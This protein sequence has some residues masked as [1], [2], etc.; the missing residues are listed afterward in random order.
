[1]LAWL[2][3]AKNY[4][5]V[6]TYGEYSRVVHNEILP[7]FRK[8]VC[9]EDIKS[10]DIKQYYAHALKTRSVKSVRRFHANIHRA[11][12]CAVEDEDIRLE[13]NP[14]RR[15]KLP[16]KTKFVSE[17]YNTDDLT[18]LF[19]VIK[20]SYLFAAVL[21]DATYGLR[22]SEL[23]GLKWGAIDFQR[24]VLF[25]KNSVVQC[26]VDGK[27]QVVIKPVLKTKSSC[28]RADYPRCTLRFQAVLHFWCQ[29]GAKR[30]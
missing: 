7:Y 19:E 21:I 23:L 24:K 13:V 5:Q 26:K 12:E 3:D 18:K 11:L 16:P 25:V 29:I 28:R 10:S 4:L 30:T 1:M 15:V 8:T 17:V 27:R 14:A 6:S 22:R 9:L 20:D 2:E